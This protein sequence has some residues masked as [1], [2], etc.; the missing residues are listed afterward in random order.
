MKTLDRRISSSFELFRTI[1]TTPPLPPLSIILLFSDPSTREL[2]KQVA[3]RLAFH[4]GFFHFSVQEYIRSLARTLTT[5]TDAEKE[6][7]LK[8]EVL[9]DLHPEALLRHVNQDRI[10]QIPAKILVGILRKRIDLLVAQGHRYVHPPTHLAT[11][12]LIY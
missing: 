4:F 5:G 7:I 9:G 12:Y 1:K 2:T 10:E 6:E 8:N 3:D 11:L